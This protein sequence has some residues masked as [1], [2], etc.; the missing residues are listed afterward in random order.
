MQVVATALICLNLPA[1]VMIAVTAAIA[2]LR[3]LTVLVNSLTKLVK[4][5]T[6]RVVPPV[7]VGPIV[8]DEP[9][10]VV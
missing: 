10:V 3:L 5:A 2:A 1:L 9:P 8:V 6:D 4:A 7:E